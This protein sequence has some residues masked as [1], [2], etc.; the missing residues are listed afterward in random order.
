[1]AVKLTRTQT[2]K[3]KQLETPRIAG[4]G[5]CPVEPGFVLEVTVGLTLTVDKVRVPKGGGWSLQYTLTDTRDV[6]A[7]KAHHLRSTPPM[8]VDENPYRCPVCNGP[9]R[10]KPWRCA[11]HGER[12]PIYRPP[13]PDEADAQ[14]REESSYT[15]RADRMQAGDAPDIGWVD[16]HAAER[17]KGDGLRRARARA[18]RLQEELRELEAA[19][20]RFQRFARETGVDA[21]SDMRVVERRIAAVKAKIEKAA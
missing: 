1:M 15:A 10:S 9:M 11:R 14:A 3:L 16:R 4:T 12:A 5:T 18:E 6:V 21:R 20:V 17:R 8:H 2:A 13:D 19:H 7:A